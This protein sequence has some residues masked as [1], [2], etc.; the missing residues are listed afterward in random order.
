MLP[1]RSLLSHRKVK[2]SLPKAP[3]LPLELW[4]GPCRGVPHTSPWM[5]LT[6]L[7]QTAVFPGSAVSPTAMPMSEGDHCSLPVAPDTDP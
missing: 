5:E 3:E 4:T 2:H 1:W 6:H 7:K